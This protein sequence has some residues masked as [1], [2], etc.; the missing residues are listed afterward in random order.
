MCNEH[1]LLEYLEDP[2]ADNDITGYLK[3]IKRFKDAMPRVKLGIKSMFK[4]NLDQIKQV[5]N[6]LC[7]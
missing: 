2:M 5:N 7:C 4:S 1:P 3:V 6:L